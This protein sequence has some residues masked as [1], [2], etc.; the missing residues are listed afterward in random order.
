MR[1]GAVLHPTV[2]LA[3]ADGACFLQHVN[4]PIRAS[5]VWPAFVHLSS[6]WKWLLNGE[7]FS[8]SFVP[9]D[10]TWLGFARAGAQGL[11]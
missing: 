10:N 3:L 9:A 8:P 6:A 11:E 4:R 5:S 7:S 2:L 1:I